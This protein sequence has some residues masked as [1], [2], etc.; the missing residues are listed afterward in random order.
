VWDEF[1][2]HCGGPGTPEGCPAVI[3]VSL[4]IVDRLDLEKG[5]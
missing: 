5:E 2:V 3:D 1:D 4:Q